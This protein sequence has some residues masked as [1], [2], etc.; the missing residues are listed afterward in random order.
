MVF[1]SGDEIKRRLLR[2]NEEKETPA[3]TEKEIAD[4]LKAIREKSQA[5]KENKSNDYG[6]YKKKIDRKF[7]EIHKLEKERKDEEIREKRE[8][9]ESEAQKPKRRSYGVSRGVERFNKKLDRIGRAAPRDMGFGDINLMQDA[10][11][12]ATMTPNRVRAS[13]KGQSF[14]PAGE[15]PYGAINMMAGMDMGAGMF[16][17]EQPRGRGRKGGNSDGGGM[18]LMRDFL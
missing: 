13:L 5:N 8:E 4:R 16:A 9:R 7:D 10:M 15:D 18:N 17:D 12:M 2:K 3:Y 1:I 11:P 14:Q 6:D